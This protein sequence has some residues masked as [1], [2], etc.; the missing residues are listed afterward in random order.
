MA[1]S[2]S[3]AKFKK[4]EI[5]FREGDSGNKMYIIQ[6]GAVEVIKKIGD[7][8]EVVLAQLKKGDFFGEMAIIDNLKRSATI[9]AV[10]DTEAI[11]FDDAVFRAQLSKLPDWFTSMFKVLSKRIRDMNNKIKSRFKMGIQ[12]SVLSLFYL[13]SEKYGKVENEKLTI[14]RSTVIEKIHGILGIPNADITNVLNEFKSNQIIEIDETTNQILILE[15]ERIAAEL[16][17]K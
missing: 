4:G 9:K 7:D 12:F 3:V 10:E 15:I 6:S 16:I 11:I 14:D 13:I 2:R 17:S 1:Q 8:D 5:V